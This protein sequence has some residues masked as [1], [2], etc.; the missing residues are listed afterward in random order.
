MIRVD[1]RM[2]LL[3]GLALSAASPA[4]AETRLFSVRTTQPNVTIVAAVRNGQQLP[5]AGQNA[6]ATFFRIDNPAGAV[7]CSNRIRFTASNGGSVD[8]PVDLCANNWELTVAVGA[9]GA[10]GGGATPPRPPAA[11]SQPLAIVTDDPNVTI[12][13]AFLNGAEVPIVARK[14]PYVQINLPGSPQ[15]FECSRDIGLA[16]SDGRRIA[17]LV[18]VCKANF[19]AIVALTG[20]PR[21]PAPPAGFRTPAVIQPLPPAA[22]PAPP[23]VVQVPAQPAPTG[24]E[25]VNTMQWLFSSGNNRASLAYA[26]PN[27]DASEF[28]AVCQQRSSKA[29][30]TLSRSADELSPGGAVAVRL[31]AGTFSKTYN[32]TGSVISELD[33]LS[34]PVIQIGISDPLWPALIRERLLTIAIGS[35]PAYAL[36]LSGSSDKAKQFLS[37]CNAAP[38]P[39]PAQPLP[40]PQPLPAPQGGTT[41]AFACDDGSY[42]N[43]AFGDGTAVVYE[44]G[45]RPI[46]LLSAPSQD[47]QRWAAGPSQLVGL[48]EQIYWT[49]DGGYARTCQRAG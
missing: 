16:L 45:S 36:S 11:T 18:D 25:I 20:G 23:P 26:L 1:F 41:M 33:G 34:H 43:V 9:G 40:Q 4:L 29:Q 49:R 38:P 35:T 44:G 21:P 22:Q 3:A 7:P 48:G 10:G 47:G 14:D 12:T 30:I 27:T 19:I 5:V 31:S 6:G 17:R 37:V 8:A 32:A 42:I 39:L 2:L 46:V 15:G 28:T 24:P 13:D